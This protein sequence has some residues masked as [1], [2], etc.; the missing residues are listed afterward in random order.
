[1]AEASHT[2]AVAAPFSI[3]LAPPHAADSTAPTAAPVAAS[4]AAPVAGEMEAPLIEPSHTLS[5][6]MPAGTHVVRP[7]GGGRDGGGG[8]IGGGGEGREKGG[9]RAGKSLA[10]K[11]L[12]E[13]TSSALF[14]RLPSL[15]C[16]NPPF[17][18][19][20]STG[21]IPI[22][23]LRPIP[24]NP[25]QFFPPATGED[26]LRPLHPHP[27]PPAGQSGARLHGT[28][29]GEVGATGVG[30]VRQGW[31]GCDRGGMG[32]T[33]V[34]WVMGATGVGWVRQGWDGCDRGGMGEPT[35][36]PPFTPVVCLSSLRTV[37]PRNGV[38]GWGPEG[39]GGVVLS[40]CYALCV[41][42][43]NIQFSVPIPLP[44]NLP[45][46]PF[47]T[48]L[49][50]T[51]LF[52]AAN[53]SLAVLSVCA[54]FMVRLMRTRL[55]PPHPAS[56]SHPIHVSMAVVSVCA[57][58]TVRTMQIDG[59]Q[60]LHT[61]QLFDWTIDTTIPTAS[62]IRVSLCKMEWGGLLSG[63]E[64]CRRVLRGVGWTND[65]SI[66]TTSIQ[67]VSLCGMVRSS[68][69]LLPRITSSLASPPPSH[70]LPCAPHPSPLPL[71][72]EKRF[73]TTYFCRVAAADGK[74]LDFGGH[75]PRKECVW[76]QHEERRSST[77]YFC[78]VA[79]ADGKQL[80]FGGHLSLEENV[81]LQHEVS[82]YLLSLAAE[83]V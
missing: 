53:V 17:S 35:P 59:S 74:Q 19:L 1:M 80:D 46:P 57:A 15:H 45:T 38:E 13:R 40:V 2:K 54:A 81:W 68:H 58:F 29:M 56:P 52:H 12:L 70:H 32:A 39:W 20:P 4:V 61:W 28:A 21:L 71:F 36:L 51:S 72:Q 47:R 22:S 23:P 64:G 31:D 6:S 8:G 82:S 79:A 26:Q 48:P 43:A 34:G 66:P 65:T 73:D 76:L 78:R 30:W 25:P 67:L 9:G 77:T 42:D 62:I 7:I 50:Y 33:G 69:H 55:S 83:S 16:A 44:F 5:D 14:I 3:A 75:L 11:K 37:S 27:A 63:A 60:L 10:K 18:S 49:F 24:L 41:H